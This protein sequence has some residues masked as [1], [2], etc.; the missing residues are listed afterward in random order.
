MDWTQAGG[1]DILPSAWSSV[2]GNTYN[3][4]LY[5]LY[6]LLLLLLFSSLQHIHHPS[7]SHPSIH[8]IPSLDCI[9][10]LL[11]YA[12]SPIDRL[13]DIGLSYQP[14]AATLHAT[15]HDILLILDI[16]CLYSSISPSLH[17][18]NIF[19]NPNPWV[20]WI[21]PCR[22][23]AIKPGLGIGLD[24]TQTGIGIRLGLGY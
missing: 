4:W 1:L 5:L 20:H 9:L 15:L 13:L 17:P 16:H 11:L 24:E 18:S 8:H 10:R 2:A 12:W 19:I 7:T 14:A 3:T 22:S 21:L 6:L 23:L